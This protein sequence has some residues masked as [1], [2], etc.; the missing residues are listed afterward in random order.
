MNCSLERA[1]NLRASSLAK[2]SPDDWESAL[3][4]PTS[5]FQ[6]FRRRAC[7]MRA[8]SKKPYGPRNAPL[9]QDLGLPRNIDPAAASLYNL[10][11]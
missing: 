1:D 7:T 11:V 2:S 10:S 9:C 3:T 5:S 4:L 8:H 6:R